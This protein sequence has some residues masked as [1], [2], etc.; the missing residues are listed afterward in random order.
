[1]KET[2][3]QEEIGDRGKSV[4]AEETKTEG[5]EGEEGARSRGMTCR[6]NGYPLA[7][8]ISA[9]LPASSGSYTTTHVFSFS[10][11]GSAFI[12][13]YTPTRVVSACGGDSTRSDPLQIVLTRACLRGRGACADFTLTSA[14]LIKT[15]PTKWGGNNQAEY[16]GTAN[17]HSTR[18]EVNEVNASPL[19]GFSFEQGGEREER[20]ER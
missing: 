18:T 1:M 17:G 11:P 3:L 12:S 10:A 2:E 4:E 15:N 14:A 19:F 13:T 8:A 6:S 16:D 5:N 7:A 9:A 20:R